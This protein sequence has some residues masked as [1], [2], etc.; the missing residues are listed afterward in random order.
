MRLLIFSSGLEVEVIRGAIN[1]NWL[2][3]T[4]QPMT[5]SAGVSPFQE[6]GCT[7]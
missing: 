6:M 1:R 5:I 4:Q 7:L 2:T 3:L